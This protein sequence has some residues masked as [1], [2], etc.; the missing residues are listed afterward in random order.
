MENSEWKANTEKEREIK[1]RFFRSR[2][3]GSPIS[4]KDRAK[5][6]GLNYF[7][8]N[9]TYRFELE[10]HEHEK[11]KVVRISYTKGQ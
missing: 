11:K 9:C 4:L 6:K 1:D 2:Y 3:P 5:F 7:P 8:P 10:L